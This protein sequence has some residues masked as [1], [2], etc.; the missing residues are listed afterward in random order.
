MSMNATH[1]SISHN[2]HGFV[3]I[4]NYADD[5][6][7]TRGTF[8]TRREAVARKAACELAESLGLGDFD[9]ISNEAA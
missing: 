5:S 7:D 9:V 4:R 6:G 8:Q 1:Y 2:S 3:V